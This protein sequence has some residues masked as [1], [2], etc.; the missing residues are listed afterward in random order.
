MSQSASQ[1]K[2]SLKVDFMVKGVKVSNPM[3]V[4]S[5]SLLIL[6]VLI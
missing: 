2:H 1:S 5:T 3:F 6:N 4:I